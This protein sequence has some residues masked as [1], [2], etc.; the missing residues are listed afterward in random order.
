MQQRGMVDICGLSLLPSW[1]L[2]HGYTFDIEFV[3]RA[4]VEKLHTKL[5]P[6]C[7]AKEWINMLL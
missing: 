4:K 7:A 6:E 1:R 2:A 3:L 5:Y